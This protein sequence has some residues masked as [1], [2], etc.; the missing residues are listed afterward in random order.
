M[1]KTMLLVSACLALT[2][3]FSL[4]AFATNQQSVSLDLNQIQTEG[5]AVIISGGDYIGMKLP[6]K[7]IDGKLYLL[8]GN[9]I[10][11]TDNWSADKYAK[12]ETLVI[13]GKSSVK[14][15]L[16]PTPEILLDNVAVPL[17]SVAKEAMESRLFPVR[18][19][20]ELAG[21]KVEY[22]A[23]SNSVTLTR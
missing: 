1:K 19:V 5:Q 4:S 16:G 8:A 18:Q 13:N 20:Y 15:R 22:D 6:A 7:I 3:V 12:N 2:M 14:L 11:V 9:S 17:D 23:I 21:Y 10:G